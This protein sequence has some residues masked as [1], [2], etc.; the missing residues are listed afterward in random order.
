MPILEVKELETHYLTH[1]VDVKAVDGISFK[2]DKGEAFGLAGESG[3]GKS[4][5]ILSILKL[6]P[7]SGRIVSGEI[8]FNGSDIL[9]MSNFEMRKIRWKKISIVFQGAMNIFDP[10]LK[11]RDQISEAILTHEK[12][13][14]D[15][16]SERIVKLFK[17][18]DIDPSRANDYPHELSGGMKQRISI[19][20]ALSCNPDFV[21]LDEPTTALDVITQAQVLETIK[22]L[23]EKS[24]L[25]IMLVSHDLSVINQMCDKISIMYAGKIVEC[26]NVTSFLERAIHPYSHGLISSFP[27][28]DGPKTRLN[29]IL[30]SLPDLGALPQGCRFHPR[31]PLSK[32]VCR[33]IE[34]EMVEV[35]SNHYVACHSIDQE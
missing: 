22:N 10:V 11:V 28:I 15:E 32:E 16:V 20:M 25:S 34:P 24:A 21:I 5:T 23:Q 35:E 33:R 26:M 17:M 2:V 18:V 13:S 30:G 12:T 27:T 1:H 7:P 3:C 19:A 8:L 6:L 31:C 9:K 4:T 29:P 14:K